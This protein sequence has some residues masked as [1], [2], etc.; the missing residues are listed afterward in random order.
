MIRKVNDYDLNDIHDLRIDQI[1]SSYLSPDEVIKI[2]QEFHNIHELVG[3][4]D[5]N[6]NNLRFDECYWKDFFPK[7]YKGKKIWRVKVYFSQNNKEK[8]SYTLYVDDLNK[9]VVFYIMGFQGGYL[10]D[11]LWNK[12]LIELPYQNSLGVIYYPSNIILKDDQNFSY[13]EESEYYKDD[14]K[15]FTFKKKQITSNNT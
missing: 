14:K 15:Y 8:K 6:V 5:N 12:P 11:C 1:V 9:K 2:V 10:D 7:S 3:I 13:S 4:V